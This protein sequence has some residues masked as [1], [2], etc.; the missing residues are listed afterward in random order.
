[1]LTWYAYTFSDQRL[2][3]L[4]ENYEIEH[5]YSK[6]RQQMERGISEVSNLESLGNKILLEER[7]NIRASD[8]RFEDK[9]RIYSGETRRG[10][11]MDMSKI[12]EF[13][14]IIKYVE[15]NEVHIIERNKAILDKFFEYLQSEDL[16]NF[17]D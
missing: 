7:I 12:A 11:N 1:M 8:Y 6:K 4:N 15:F 17:S 2:V 3:D 5:I 10:L 14:D 13:S 16:L 9:Q